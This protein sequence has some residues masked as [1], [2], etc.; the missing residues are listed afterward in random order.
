MIFLGETHTFLTNS[1]SQWCLSLQRILA[2]LLLCLLAVFT[3]AGAQAP[4]IIHPDPATSTPGGHP[5]SPFARIHEPGVALVLSGGGARGI[6][7]IGVLKALE[8]HGVPVDFIAATSLGAIVGGLY[9]AGYT[10][11][12]LESIAVVTQWDEVLSLT[13][14][15]RRRD[16]FV[17]QKV[18]ADRS[19][20]VV[21]FEGLQPV[22]P[23][24]VSSGQR[25]TNFLNEL[26]LQAVYHPNPDFDDLPIRFRAVST[27]LISG[28]RVTLRDGSLAE[29]LRASATVPLLFSPIER[30]S[31]KL[32]DGGLVSNIPVD[33]ARQ[34]G[35][36]IVVAVNSTSGLRN[37]NELNAPWQT[38]DQIMGIMMQLSNEQ[39]LR[40]ADVV[41]TPDIGRHLSS[42]FTG[43]DSLIAA[44]ERSAEQHMGEILA[45]IRSR[46]RKEP[47]VAYRDPVIAYR[48]TIP[49]SLLNLF[50]TAGEHGMI[51]TGTI[52]AC[53]NALH[54]EGAY[55]EVHAE[56]RPGG[57]RTDI[58]FVAESNPPMEAIQLDG[59]RLIPPETVNSE[60][61]GMVGK[62]LNWIDVHRS[63]VNIIRLYRS[64]GYSLAR[65]D[66]VFF[67]GEGGTLHVVMNEGIIRDVNVEG[68]VRTQD[69]F[70]LREF[71]LHPGD[72]F[73]ID[74]ANEGITNINS[75]T[76][77]EYVYLEISYDGRAPVV[78]IRLRE[79]PSQLIRFGLRAD[80][81]R[82]LQG[83]IDIRD[84]NFRGTG[85]D[86]GLNLV[87]GG[88]NKRAVLEY[89]ANRIFDTYLTFNV[90]AFF[91]LF[92]SYRYVDAPPPSENRWN[93]IIEGQYR[94]TRYGGRL[95]FGAQLQK[96]G[97]A[98][99][100][101][102]LQNV[103][104]SNLENLEDEMLDERN[105]LAQV[106]IGTVIDSKDSYPFPD[107]GIGMNLSYE[108]SFKGLG[109]DVGFNAVRFMYESFSTWDVRHTFHPKVTFGFADKTMPLSEQFRLGGREM[110]YGTREDDRRG[111]QMLL[112]NL[113]YRYKLPFRVVF[114]SYI[115]ARYDLG[116]ISDVPEQ[117]KIKEFRHGIGAELGVD[118]P[119]GPAAFGVG[120]SFYFSQ[121]LP[122]NP[123]QEGPFL[124]YFMVGFQR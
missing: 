84:E 38:A 50:A 9:A 29:A 30:D 116:T 51:A 111:R 35:N 71:P 121:S 7:Q 95:V 66:T 117:I 49:D 82:N 26:T 105:R 79:R 5:H 41:I 74:R 3:P 11:A 69:S 17:D 63:L 110:L 48:G 20:L 37:S 60:F 27:D 119:I 16:L 39:E 97:N 94:D 108:F 55:G 56:I 8:K 86:L 106:R 85:L 54:N 46:R 118:T 76:L 59:C 42:D 12:E 77:F 64:Q 28:R 45:A 24:A 88:R 25:L 120:K 13:D 31:M 67:R 75:T 87:I 61:A 21:R 6:A 19:F 92:D 124:F 57:D 65:V 58:L 83:L 114:D 70:V 78:T 99:M 40:Q 91:D 43:V 73:Q 100:E 47:G 109:S 10:T 14:E 32:I 112:V 72:V 34:N 1:L 36:S 52:R 98:T 2:G 23:P 89:R 101:L 113:E 33:I 22:I 107:F 93:R 102:V 90:S 62:P 68:G 115:S 123:I 122:K 81:E 4:I 15:T 44:G 96:F 104:T 80:N 18:A 53:L 103:R